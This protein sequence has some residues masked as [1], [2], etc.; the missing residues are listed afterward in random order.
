MKTSS[1]LFVMIAGLV[2]ASCQK[3]ASDEIDYGSVTDSVYSN[4]YFGFQ[5]PL[6][7]EWSVQDQ[8]M[9][10]ELAKSGTQLIAGENIDMKAAL[11]ASEQQTVNLMAVFQHPVGSPVPFN[12][13]VNCV[14]ERIRHMPGIQRGRDYHFHAKKL[15]SSGQIKAEFPKEIVSE[16]LD[17]VDFDVMAVNLGVAD[18]TVRQKYYAAIIKGYA[19]LFIVSFTTPEEETATQAILNGVKFKR[20]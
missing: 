7:N 10:Q 6:P 18:M 8:A 5:L 16:K 4:A 17:G 11:K 19:L 15:L 14:A 12:P 2:L 9:R 3:K 1:L 13:S 20:E